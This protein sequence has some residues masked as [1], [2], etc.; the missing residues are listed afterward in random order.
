LILEEEPEPV[1]VPSEGGEIEV[2]RKPVTVGGIAPFHY[3]T[4]TAGDR[5]NLFIRKGDSYP[6]EEPKTQTFYTRAP[7]QR[8]V[9][10]PVYGGDNLETASAN[11][12]QGQAYAIL[13]P[14]LPSDTPVRITLALDDDGVFV[15]TA[16]LGDGR[17]LDPW[18]VKGDADA[19]AIEGLERAEAAL[20][21]KAGA[22]S[23]Q[24]RARLERL[25][26]AVFDRM[27]AR[28][29]DG[30]VDEAERLEKE[31]ADATPVGT[32]GGAGGGMSTRDK[33][34]ALTRFAEFVLSEYAWAFDDPNMV[35]RITKAVEETK[36]ALARGDEA[37]LKQAVAA[38]DKVTD[39][40]PQAVQ[41]FLALKSAILSQIQPADP[42]T[43]ASL[44]AEVGDIERGLRGGNMTVLLR[45]ESV[46]Q[47]VQ[48][49]IQDAQNRRLLVRRCESCGAEMGGERYCPKCHADSWLPGG[50]TSS[51]T[52]P[53]R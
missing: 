40:L 39:D 25:R 5:F 51:S 45:L 33:A 23:P 13:P 50:K 42:A 38:L 36:E 7:R 48:A 4:Q 11:E 29:F 34:E 26:E 46:F 12:L 47:K 16:Y 41:A 44:L 53:S 32:G 10:I 31:V 8:M 35:Y 17:R 20:A 43:A 3:G 27:K 22:L 30:A 2:I 6:T 19:A 14:D 9:S 52:G 37:R 1:E 49:A 21:A 24:E 28:D 15:L 18:I